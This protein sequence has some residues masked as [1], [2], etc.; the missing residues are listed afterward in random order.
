MA[1]LKQIR[2]ERLQLS[3]EAL[4]AKL[5]VT[6][7]NVS[8]YEVRGQVMPPRVARRLIDYCRSVGVEI[9]FDEIYSGVTAES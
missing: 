1:N 4:A 6:Q 5:G 7:A 8:F 2:T 9:S 3:Q